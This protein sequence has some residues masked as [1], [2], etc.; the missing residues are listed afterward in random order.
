[1]G[2][3]GVRTGE[4]VSVGFFAGVVVA[5]IAPA[6]DAAVTG[7]EVELSAG[8]FVGL[9]A[10][11]FQTPDF[12]LASMEEFGATGFQTPDLEPASGEE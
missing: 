9:E 6:A 12:E 11:G 4:V 8:L 2:F 3:A 5:I 1:V 7:T 10:T